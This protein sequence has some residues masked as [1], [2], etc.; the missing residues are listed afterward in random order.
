MHTGTFSLPSIC[1]PPGQA[2]EGNVV[3]AT[4]RIG[5]VHNSPC[6]HMQGWVAHLVLPV[7]EKRSGQGLPLS[8]GTPAHPVPL[9]RQGLTPLKPY[10]SAAKKRKLNGKSPLGCGGR[11]Q[12]MSNISPSL[13]LTPSVATV[14]QHVTAG[15]R[16]LLN[17][18]GA[19]ASLMYI[20][21][22]S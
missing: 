16:R 21:H 3:S 10:L 5:A 12:P 11:Q 22:W 4:A 20:S 9:N 18:I 7:P 14:P 1:R 17:P 19:C 6:T 2:L 13:Y 8:Q 15:S